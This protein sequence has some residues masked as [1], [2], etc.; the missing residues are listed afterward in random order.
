M[1]ICLERVSKLHPTLATLS[2]PPKY[3]GFFL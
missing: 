1:L 3:Q 2:T